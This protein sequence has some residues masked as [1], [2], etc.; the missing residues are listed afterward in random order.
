MR[1]FPVDA[2][3]ELVAALRREL[4]S[5]DVVLIKGSRGLE[6]ETVVAELRQRPDDAEET[7]S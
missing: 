5:G 2:K 3:D 6:M 4:R 7:G 1:T